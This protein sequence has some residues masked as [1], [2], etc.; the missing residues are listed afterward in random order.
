[1]EAGTPDDERDD[2]ERAARGDLEAFER[3]Y[4]RHAPRVHSLARRLLGSSEAEDATQEVFLRAWRKLGTYRG[5][6]AF[7][8]WLGRLAGR[9]LVSRARLRRDAWEPIAAPEPLGVPSPPTREGG[10]VD[11]EA[12]IAAL[13]AGARLVLVLHDIEGYDHAEIAR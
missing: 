9:L 4:R 6:G 5:E 10:S 2:V 3:L 12:A 7:A 11:L 1:M 8:A 13:P